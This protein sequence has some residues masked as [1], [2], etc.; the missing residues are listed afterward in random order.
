MKYPIK[1]IPRGLSIVSLLVVGAILAYVAIIGAK[2]VPTAT[3]YMAVKNAVKEAA[4]SG[5]TVATIRQ[6]FDRHADAGYIT[7]IRGSD[8]EV[9][10]ADGKFVVG[11]NYEKQIPLGGPAYL[12]LKYRGSATGNSV[13]DK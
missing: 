11:F 8:L 5:T 2:V 10:K 1:R 4:Q 9:S 13:G 12:L 3:E 7:S 6:S